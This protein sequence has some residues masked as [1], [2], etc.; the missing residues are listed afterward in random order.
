MRVTATLA[1]LGLA[2]SL[3]AG[4]ALAQTA[5]TPAPATPAPAATGGK[6]DKT[7]ISK[8]CSQQADAQGL[9]GK[10]RKSFRNKCK[11]NGGK[12]S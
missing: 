10:A 12:P 9:H 4:S 3:M 6:M 11:E 5:T 8:A 2:C 1:A 7:A